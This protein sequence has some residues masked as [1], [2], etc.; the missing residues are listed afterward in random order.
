MA[1]KK[2]K[3]PVPHKTAPPAKK[4]GVGA[5]TWAAVAVA[6]V[7]LV[8]VVVV[9]GNGGSK[10]VSGATAPVS[11][12]ATAASGAAPAAVPP[13][14]AKY[15]G[16]LLPAGYVEPTVAPAAAYASTLAMFNVTPAQGPKQTSVS[17]ADVVANKIVYFEYRKAGSDPVPMV[18]YVKP[19]GKLFVGVSFCIPCKSKGQTLEADGTLRCNA[20][21]TKRDAETGVGISGACRLYP[22]DELP[23][24]VA[25]G[26]I[27]I[28]NAAMDQWTPQPLDRKVGV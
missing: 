21:G 20:C 9:A 26:K 27:V 16:R 28:D 6:A 7:A 10:G 5:T 24:K 22:L 3:S 19:S 14:E 1:K 23:A 15:I 18:A 25:G 2:T 8:V 12:G 11:A 17:V 4:K 13:E